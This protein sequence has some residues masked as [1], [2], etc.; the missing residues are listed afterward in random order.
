M[1][2]IFIMLMLIAIIASLASAL[3][4]L[5]TGSGSSRSTV[6]AL[7]VRIGLSVALFILLMAAHWFGLIEPSVGPRSP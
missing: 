4:Y 2:R 3:Y 5:F 6:R 7:T 1:V